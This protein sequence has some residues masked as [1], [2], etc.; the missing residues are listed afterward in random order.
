M[1]RLLEVSGFLRIRDRGLHPDHGLPPGL[2][3]G[4]PDQGLPGEGGGDPGYGYPE[5]PVDPGYGLPAPP[6]GIWPP[7]GP[8]HPIVPAPPGTPPG[9][10]WPPIGQTP[11]WPDQGLPPVSPG[12]PSHPISGGGEPTHP[13]APPSGF[14]SHPIEGVYWV[15][16]LI[17]GVGWRYTTIAPGLQPS[18][19]IAPGVSHPIVPPA[20]SPGA[21]DQGLPQPQ[22][23]PT[24][25]GRR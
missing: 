5:S 18:H 21:P 8:S 13:I 24:P 20:G 16:V 14:P 17:P 19:P 11:G 4:A 3:P 1:A 23:E 9:V 12:T 25:H 15:I 2:S 10:I 6:P 7:I 22:P